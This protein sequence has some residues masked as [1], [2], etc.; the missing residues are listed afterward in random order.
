MTLPSVPD[1]I[2]NDGASPRRW[3]VKVISAVALLAATGGFIVGRAS[4]PSDALPPTAFLD[5]NPPLS[6]RMLH[7]NLSWGADAES[8]ALDAGDGH[9]ID[10]D[11]SQQDNQQLTDAIAHQYEAQGEYM[12]T[13]TA[14]RGRA[15]AEATCIFTAAD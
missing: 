13:L 7:V 10:L 3:P 14:R 6:D 5:C 1:V 15:E 12:V 4:A 2:G 8:V 11:A 9:V